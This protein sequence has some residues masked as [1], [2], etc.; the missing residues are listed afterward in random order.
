MEILF[1]EDYTLCSLEPWY[2]E[3]KIR[4]GTQKDGRIMQIIGN[5]TLGFISYLKK[6]DS[7]RNFKFAELNIYEEKTVEES[8][9]AIFYQ[10][11]SSNED[12]I[13]FLLILSK[14]SFDVLSYYYDNN[15]TKEI[16]FD[17]FISKKKDDFNKW[18]VNDGSLSFNGINLRK[19]NISYKNG[20]PNNFD[21]HLGEWKSDVN[22]N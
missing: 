5:A 3:Y 2:W 15:K 21:I 6:E 19:T 11:E 16:V 7:P 13:H 22:W 10:P 8:N 1:M 18:I 12:T 17:M 9:N 20:Y 4:L 14:E